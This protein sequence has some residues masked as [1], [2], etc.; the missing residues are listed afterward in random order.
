MSREPRLTATGK[1]TLF[2][3]RIPQILPQEFLGD[4]AL[5]AQALEPTET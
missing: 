3:A 1:Q 2:L 4:A 5:P